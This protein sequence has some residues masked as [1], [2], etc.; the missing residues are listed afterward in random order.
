M[1]HSKW[2][3]FVYGFGAGIGLGGAHSSV[4]GALRPS[5]VDQGSEALGLFGALGFRVEGSET[6]F[7]VYG[8]GFRF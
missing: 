4:G 2:R 1:G 7:R 3:E 5:G 6:G 8:L